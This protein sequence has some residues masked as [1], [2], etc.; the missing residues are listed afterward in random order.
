[1]EINLKNK[2]NRIYNNIIIVSIIFILLSILNILFNFID[3][4]YSIAV[5]I[6]ASI[7]S[8]VMFIQKNRFKKECIEN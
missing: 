1:M 3:I 5:I 8:L 7:G 2:I 4:N 6:C